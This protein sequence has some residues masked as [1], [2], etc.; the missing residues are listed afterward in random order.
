M[1][2]QLKLF[3]IFMLVVALLT[4]GLLE[5]NF[6]KNSED[7]EESQKKIIAKDDNSKN[8]E[9][10]VEEQ[11]IKNNKILNLIKE[12][13][14]LINQRLE[15]VGG[16]KVDEE[17]KKICEG[18][19]QV[20]KTNDLSQEELI[21][22]LLE[23]TEEKLKSK[24]IS[25]SNKENEEGLIKTENKSNIDLKINISEDEEKQKSSVKEG[26]NQS[27]K[28]IV[29]KDKMFL[30]IRDGYVALYQGDNLENVE[31]KEIKKAIPIKKLP[32]KDQKELLKG[33][34]VNNQ[35][36]LLSILEGFLAAINE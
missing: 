8:V 7:K 11:L 28:E 20:S 16:I 14:K 33:I 10:S 4:Y 12:E 23:Y 15:A 19:N 25:K 22:S 27:E 5:L 31:L 2:K 29:I 32:K 26:E 17:L 36:E 9:L 35:E 24:E 13:E 21:Q 34:E 6:V 3:A 18:L 1:Y 30:G